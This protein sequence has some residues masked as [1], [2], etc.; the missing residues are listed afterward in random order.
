MKDGELVTNSNLTTVVRS[1]DP[2]KTL[3]SDRH[4]ENG[5]V[6]KPRGLMKDR[7]GAALPT[8]EPCSCFM[9]TTT[10]HRLN[11]DEEKFNVIS[12]IVCGGTQD[13]RMH[14]EVRSNLLPALPTAASAT[15]VI[16]NDDIQRIAAAVLAALEDIK[17]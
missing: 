17:P 6:S 12:C 4:P 10:Q 7:Y 14:P 13:K 8:G 1:G 5:E 3:F 16:S 2:G 11:R 15:L 9:T